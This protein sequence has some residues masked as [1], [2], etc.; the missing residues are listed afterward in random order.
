[1]V[2]YFQN[3]ASG[4]RPEPDEQLKK[5]FEQ[6]LSEQPLHFAEGMYEGFGKVE[7]ADRKLRNAVN[8]NKDYATIRKLTL[9]LLVAAWRFYRRDFE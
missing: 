4:K 2:G 8:H 5:D 3:F 9:D 1:M 6:R 7:K